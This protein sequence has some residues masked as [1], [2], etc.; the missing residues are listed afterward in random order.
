MG[1]IG[2]PRS[3]FLMQPHDF[4]C[5]RLIEGVV[6]FGDGNRRNAVANQIGDG[7]GFVHE[8]VN[9][10]QKDKTGNRNGVD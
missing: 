10:E 4:P 1:I 3:A 9:A 2:W 7:T 5:L 8:A 6:P